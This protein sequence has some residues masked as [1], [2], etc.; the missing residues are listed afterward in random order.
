MLLNGGAFPD[1]LDPRKREMT[2]EHLLTMSSG[3]WCDDTDPQAPGNEETISEQTGE[4][5]YWRYTLGVPMATDPGQKA[6]YCSC[7]PNL[8]L[9]MLE[10][11]TGESGLLT[12]DRLVGEPLQIRRYGWAL[13]P[14]GNPYGGGSVNFLPRDFMKLGQL[15]LN[16]GTWRGRR[17]LSSEFAQQI[18]SRLYHLRRIYYG[19]L[20]WAM[21]VPY[22][23]RTV[24]VYF[25]AGSGGQGV[26]VVPELDLV[27]ATYGANYSA[28]RVAIR[29]TQELLPR[30][31]LPAVREKGDDPGTPVQPIEFRTPYG[32]SDDGSPV[33]SR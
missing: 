8:A 26:L 4:P 1:D 5:S 10:Q 22:K 19:Y 7:N 21:D 18:R 28:G 32:R 16:G 17:I 12:F 11:A 24:E 31:I 9:A 14:A 2:L 20:W 13:D 23:D 33:T 25:A 3:Y 27:V 30:F 6:V 15:L 29:I